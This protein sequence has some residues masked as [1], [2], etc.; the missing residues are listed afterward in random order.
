MNLLEQVKREQATSNALKEQLEET[1]V[2]LK[3]VVEEKRR[4]YKKLSKV[5]LQQEEKELQDIIDRQQGTESISDHLDVR[6]AY[7]Q[8]PG[9]SKVRLKESNNITSTRTNFMDSDVGI[10]SN[11]ELESNLKNELKTLD[12]QIGK[13]YCAFSNELEKLTIYSIVFETSEALKEK[14]GRAALVQSQRILSDVIDSSL[15]QLPNIV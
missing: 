15:A 3:R 7:E 14:L 2:D 10:S 9:E 5:S 11:I 12:E 1:Y 13:V 6:D 4:L 8:R